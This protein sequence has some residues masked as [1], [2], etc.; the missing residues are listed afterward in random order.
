MDTQK[1]RNMK[2]KKSNLILLLLSGL[3]LIISMVL[4]VKVG[5]Y[6]DGYGTTPSLVYGDNFWLYMAWLRLLLLMGIVFILGL[7]VSQKK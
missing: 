3:T 7:K 5:K 1:T 2:E 6:V 4:F